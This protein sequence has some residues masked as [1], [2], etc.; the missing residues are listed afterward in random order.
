MNINN[1]NTSID[2][3]EAI[4]EIESNPNNYVDNAGYTLT[5]HAKK[6]IDI[7]SERLESCIDEEGFTFS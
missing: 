5:E 1:L 7:L 4:E 3:F 6:T 2:F